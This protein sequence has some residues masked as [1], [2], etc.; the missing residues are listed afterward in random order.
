MPRIVTLPPLE[1]L[2]RLFYVEDGKLYRKEIER[3]N[4]ISVNAWNKLAK[5]K[6]PIDLYRVQM[7]SSGYKTQFRVKTI[8]IALTEGIDTAV[9]AHKADVIEKLKESQRLRLE[10]N[11][12]HKYISKVKPTIKELL[13][14]AK[15]KPSPIDYVID[16]LIDENY[17]PDNK[18]KKTKAYPFFYRGSYSTE[19]RA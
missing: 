9:D 4:K 5:K 12:E 8:I 1:T 16:N 14:A 18:A 3:T 17:C 19:C 15:D 7:Q 2:Q 13:Q 6:E 11:S 10:N